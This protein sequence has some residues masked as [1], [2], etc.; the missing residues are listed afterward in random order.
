M[1][2]QS[3]RRTAPSTPAVTSILP[4][5]VND[6]AFC[7]RNPNHSF[8]HSVGLHGCPASFVPDH[9]LPCSRRSRSGILDSRKACWINPHTEQ[10]CS[11]FFEEEKKGGGA[12]LLVRA[13]LDQAALVLCPARQDSFLFF[14]REHTWQTQH[15]R[16][17]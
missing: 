2:V 8:D 15:K 4:S 16:S 5:G 6:T 13:E 1:S 10:R 17:E 12:A 14:I 9:S 7:G 11:I 3:Q